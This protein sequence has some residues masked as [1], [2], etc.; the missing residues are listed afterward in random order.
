[1]VLVEV[2]DWRNTPADPGPGA[3]VSASEAQAGPRSAAPYA[4]SAVYTKTGN[5]GPCCRALL[6]GDRSRGPAAGRPQA[7]ASGRKRRTL[8]MGAGLNALDTIRPGPARTVP[9]RTGPAWTGTTR[10]YGP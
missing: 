7:A 2:V 9:G 3:L 8:R 1:M 6:G 5:A 10:P 4:R